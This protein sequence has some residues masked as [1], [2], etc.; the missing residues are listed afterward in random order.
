MIENFLTAFIVYFVVIDPIGTAPIFL[1]VTAAQDKRAKIRTAIEA[2]LVATLIMVFFALCGSWVLRY[3]QIGEPA[4]KIAG[5][6][7]LFLVA[8]DMLT[9]KRQTRKRLET[10]GPATGPTPA[11]AAEAGTAEAGARTTP[12]KQQTKDTTGN[13]D[14]PE[15]V[16][17]FPLAIPMLAGPAAI[18]SVMVVSADFSGSMVMSLTGYGALL[19]V[20]LATGKIMVLTAI[21]DRMIDPRL[22]NV[23]SRVTAIILAALSVQYVIDGMTAL[24]LI[25]AP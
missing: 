12:G 22:S 6:V 19:A 17:I 4:F 7:I 18:M 15:N 11:F 20:M 24:Q 13:D 9:S 14:E 1:A 8:W 2:T 3:L 5:G 16:A 10:T 23:F 25:A 21:A